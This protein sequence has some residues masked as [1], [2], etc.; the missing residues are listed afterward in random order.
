MRRIGQKFAHIHGSGMRTVFGGIG[1]KCP[2]III[3][4]LRATS[5]GIP[6]EAHCV[7]ATN[8]PFSGIGRASRWKRRHLLPIFVAIITTDQNAPCAAFQARRSS[9]SINRRGRFAVD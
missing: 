4:G 5:R 3:A 2:I 8:Q 1:S 6:S 9:E 7:F